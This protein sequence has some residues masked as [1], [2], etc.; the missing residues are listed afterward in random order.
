LH[1]TKYKAKNGELVE[2]ETGKLYEYTRA[3]PYGPGQSS[4]IGRVDHY[5]KRF[6]MEHLG[7]K[8]RRLLGMK[9]EE[10][11]HEATFRSRDPGCQV[12]FLQQHDPLHENCADD[13]LYNM[14]WN[15]VS[16]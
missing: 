16:G 10:E 12:S 5:S 13:S 8:E 15:D 3:K 6:Q 7:S 2:V 1:S 11:P 9:E 14:D 4:D